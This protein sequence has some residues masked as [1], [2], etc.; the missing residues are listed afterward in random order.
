MHRCIG[1]SLNPVT[2]TVKTGVDG[3]FGPQIAF[4]CPG[5][6]DIVLTGMTGRVGVSTLGL[7]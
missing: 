3:T 1:S 6:K 2:P 4:P 7:M 5:V